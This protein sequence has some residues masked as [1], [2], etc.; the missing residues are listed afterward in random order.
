VEE[1]PGH[2]ADLVEELEGDDRLL[3]IDGA[4]RHEEPEV[5]VDL[6]GGGVRDAPVV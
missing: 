3:V 5:A 1:P 4:R 2:G 6:L